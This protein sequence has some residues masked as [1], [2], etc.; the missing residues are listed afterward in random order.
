MS[1][2]A[3]GLRP[4]C[5]DD[6][7]DV[8]RIYEYYVLHS[9]V[10][11][12]IDPPTADEMARRYRGLIADGY[13][14]LA[15]TGAERVVGYAYAGPYRKRPAYRY[16]VENSVYLDPAWVGRGIGRRLLERLIRE[17]A[18]R[19]SRQMLA[20]IGDSAN[21][22]SVRLHARCG[23]MLVGTFAAVGFKH[24]RWVDT[25]LMQRPLGAGDAPL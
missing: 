8:A 7:A 12:E 4:A 20:I 2:D 11:F 16:C 21:R 25:V 24:G 18:F 17:S 14:Y 23:F 19:G 10:T 1:V 13:P 6:M 9:L 3:I 5:V 15:V 22:A